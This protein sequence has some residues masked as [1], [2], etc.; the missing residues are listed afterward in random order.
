MR[1]AS[2][3]VFVLSTSILFACG[4]Q[5]A[6]EEA[7]ATAS[8]EVAAAP[9]SPASPRPANPSCRAPGVALVPQRLSQLGCFD[10]KRGME[11]LVGLW[12]YDV[13]APLW[14]DDADKQRWFAMPDDATLQ[15]DAS[16]R[17]VL[18]P[19]ALVLKLF[20]HAGQPLE[21]R[22][23]MNHPDAGWRGYAYRWQPDGDAVLVDGESVDVPLAGGGA[24]WTIPSRSQCTECHR[25]ADNPLLGLTIAQLDRASSGSNESQ[26]AAL[27]TAGF[28]TADPGVT[29]NE[30]TRLVDP[31]DPSESLDARARSYLHANCSHCHDRAEGYCTGD[32]RIATPGAASGLCDVSPRALDASSGWLPDTRLIAPGDPERSALWLRLTAPPTSG[33]AMPPLGHNQIDAAGVEL[34]AA[35]IS[36]QASCSP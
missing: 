9:Q 1:D 11:P 4:A 33:L 16:G 30:S 24:H 6:E 17:F 12:A 2:S 5:L 26:L 10:A 29:T 36:A 22:V 15:I 19:G 13:N 8:F 31:R 25:D 27:V 28:L 34:I 18:P 3:I 14:S 7:A 23:W 21:T 20:A 35:W 32:L